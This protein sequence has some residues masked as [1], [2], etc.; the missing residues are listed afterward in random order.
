MGVPPPLVDITPPQT[1]V[2]TGTN[3]QQWAALLPML[4]AVCRWLDD[5]G[6]VM[7]RWRVPAAVAKKIG[8]S[9][10]SECATPGCHCRCLL[11]YEDGFLVDTNWR[12]MGW[13]FID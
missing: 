9:A 10:D 12:D 3:R 2:F 13:Y 11:K 6:N 5:R 1:L 7:V 8:L 4:N